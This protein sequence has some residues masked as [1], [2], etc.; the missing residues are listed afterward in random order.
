[1]EIGKLDRVGTCLLNGYYH[2]VRL[3]PNQPIF[4]VQV[5][6]LFVVTWL[7]S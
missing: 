4:L 5:E 6:V 1:M 2:Q 3:R 7:S